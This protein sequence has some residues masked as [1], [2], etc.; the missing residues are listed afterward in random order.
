IMRTRSGRV[1]TAKAYEH[2][3]YEYSEK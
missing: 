3:G 1:A 2:L